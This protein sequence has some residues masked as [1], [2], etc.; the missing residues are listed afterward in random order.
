MPADPILGQIMPVAFNSVLPK[1][2]ALCDGSLISIQQNQALFSLIGTTYGGNGTINF[3]LPDLRGRAIL[4]SSGPVGTY[5]AGTKAGTTTVMLTTSTI[6]AHTHAIQAS[7]AVGSGK[8]TPPTGNYFGVAADGKK[9]FGTP[10]SAEVLLAISTNVANDGGNQGH[11]NMQPYLT[12]NY[13]IATSG[14][15]PSRD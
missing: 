8:T 4:G 15:Y 11:N 2:W 3:G 5:P 10:G 9:I 12:I 7:T 14:T 6:A 13:M 1:G